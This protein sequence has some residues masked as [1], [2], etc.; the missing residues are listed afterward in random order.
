MMTRYPELQSGFLAYPGERLL[1]RVEEPKPSPA[2]MTIQPHLSRTQQEYFF[3][4][5][6]E[7]LCNVATNSPFKLSDFKFQQEVFEVCGV[8]FDR[9][10]IFSWMRVQEEG[11]HI[12]F[13]HRLFLEDTLKLVM[14]S[15]PRMQAPQQ[16]ATQLSTACDPSVKRFKAS[17]VTEAVG[18]RPTDDL[19]S[20]LHQW[21]QR[22][23][24]GDL[25]L[26]MQVI[27]GRRTLHASYGAAPY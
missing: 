2:A 23:G 4:G 1:T 12:S 15:Q 18:S 16:W 10:S 22:G 13:Q 25:I 26:S 14:L 21:V 24:M 8:L 5:E 19:T 9:K 3:S 7:K 17:D 6:V 20:F 11:R 27:F